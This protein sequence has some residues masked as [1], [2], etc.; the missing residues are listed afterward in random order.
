MRTPESLS[1]VTPDDIGTELDQNYA[2][3]LQETIQNETISNIRNFI[4]SLIR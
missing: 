2:I 3:C 4:V 1:L